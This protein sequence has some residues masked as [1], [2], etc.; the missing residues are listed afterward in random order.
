MAVSIIGG[1]SSAVADVSPDS[2]ALKVEQRPF[3]YVTG[4]SYMLCSKSGTMAA[5]LGANA[6]IYAFRNASANLLICVRRVKLTAWSLGTGFA[7]G[8]ATFDVY[9]A[10]SWS[11]PDTAG[12][13]DTITTNNGKLRTAQPTIAAL[14]EIR[15]ASTGGLTAGTRVLDAQPTDSINVTVSAT[16]NTAFV[17]FPTNLLARG[18]GEYPLVLAQNEGFVIQATVP[19]TGT[20]SWAITPEWDETQA[21][22]P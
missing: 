3:D 1:G 11:A 8:I 12:V 17:T 14:A 16:A 7:A 22:A 18:P 20:W 4:G 21:Y 10:T 19:A 6:P 13:T 15:H 9:R 5:G 2:L